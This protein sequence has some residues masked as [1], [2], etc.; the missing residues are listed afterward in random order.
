[1]NKLEELQAEHQKLLE[2]YEANHDSN[3]LLNAVHSYIKRV[4]VEAEL[5]P[6]P[7]D[8]DQLRANLRFWASFIFDKTGIY[9]ETTLWPVQTSY[10]AY[11]RFAPLSLLALLITFGLIIM[12][13]PVWDRVFAWLIAVNVVAF[14]AFGYDKAMAQTGAT[15]IPEALLLALTVL[16]GA[17]GSI[18]GMIVLRHKTQKTSFLLTFG[19]CVLVSIALIVLYYW[20][21]CPECG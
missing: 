2:E 5:V 14:L 11:L 15:R 19:A 13:V 6:L 1:M 17:I 21:L 4:R 3:E 9:P 12:V 10:N 20:R 8:R 7:R 16:G 18:L